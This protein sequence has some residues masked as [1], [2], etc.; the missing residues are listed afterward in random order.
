[1][2]FKNYIKSLFNFENAEQEKR[3]IEDAELIRR[4]QEREAIRREEENKRG[5]WLESIRS[6]YFNKSD[7]V[8]FVQFGYEK[9]EDNRYFMCG[10]LNADGSRFKDL[11]TGDVYDVFDAP[12][13]NSNVPEGE[14]MCSTISIDD[15][16]FVRV[17]AK[18]VENKSNAKLLELDMDNTALASKT[19]CGDSVLVVCNFD[20]REDSVPLYDLF[21]I[22]AN[23][24]VISGR[25]VIRA[26]N[27]GNFLCA[28]MVN[29]KMG[30][31]MRKAQLAE[32]VRL[33]EDIKN[34]ASP[35]PEE[36]DF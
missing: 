16:P 24:G 5:K 29:M 12:Y 30:E 14:S 34:G 9:K 13:P 3:R 21:N 36:L 26:I 33:N 17:G 32:N 28:G 27:E 2:S 23:N 15:R 22:E 31:K 4:D 8:Y 1:M 7:L 11:T 20:Y 35:T 19:F 10:Y 6:R 25:D 18:V